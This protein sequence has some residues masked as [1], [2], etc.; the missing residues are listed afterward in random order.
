VLRGKKKKKKVKGAGDTTNLSVG[1]GTNREVGRR[2]TRC[3]RENVCFFGTE[4]PKPQN[5]W[6]RMSGLMK[7]KNVTGAPV[8]TANDKSGIQDREIGHQGGGSFKMIRKGRLRL[9]SLWGGTRVQGQQLDKQKEI[10]MG[11]GFD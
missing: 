10:S 7:M 6:R 8:K 5:A 1:G 2:G 3:E 11:I 4:L 9:H